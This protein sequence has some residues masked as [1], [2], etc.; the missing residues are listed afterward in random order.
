MEK[1]EKPHVLKM[2]DLLNYEE[3]ECR[4]GVIIE[5]NNEPRFTF[6]WNL[7]QEE[8]EGKLYDFYEFFQKLGMTDIFNPSNTVAYI[9]GNTHIFILLNALINK[10]PGKI[11]VDRRSL[12]G[13]SEQTAEWIYVNNRAK[14]RKMEL[15]LV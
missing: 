1:K 2:L 9:R 15:I 5:K 3:D 8:K 6:S 7:W 12:N 13:Q 14:T 4:I 10:N 11:Y